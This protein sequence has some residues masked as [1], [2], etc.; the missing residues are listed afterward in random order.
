MTNE[1]ASL[2]CYIKI[3]LFQLGLCLI[4][5]S[6]SNFNSVMEIRPIAS[7]EAQTLRLFAEKTFRIAWEHLNPGK[8]DFEAYCAA[9]F[10]PETM[11]NELSAPKTRFFAA[12]EA[13]KWLAYLKLNYAVH[14]EA[15]PEIGAA[16]QVERIYVDPDT[17]SRGIGARL[18]AFAEQEARSAGLQTVWLSVWTEAPRSVAFYEKQGYRTFGTEIFWVGNDPQ[19]DW[20]MKKDLTAEQTPQHE[21]TPTASAAGKGTASGKLFF[22]LHL[23]LTLG[24]WIAP[25]IID[26]RILVPVYLLVMLQFAVF[27]KC[28]MNEMH[29]TQESE[30]RIF[31]TELLEYFGWRPNPRKLKFFVRKLLYPTLALLAILWQVVL[32]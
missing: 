3:C 30:D 8:T 2:L 17:Q 10:T 11:L 1:I 7:A 23:V 27:K 5:L 29:E 21:N 24:A 6:L 25:F 22:F 12:V 20:L 32:K 13:E 26:W 19:N 15:H 18:M 14:P 4:L 31:Y 28:L 16:L 9:A